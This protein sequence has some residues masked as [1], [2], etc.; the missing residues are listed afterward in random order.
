MRLHFLYG[1]QIINSW[2]NVS[3]SKLVIIRIPMMLKED[4]GP[5][6]LYFDYYVLVLEIN[7]HER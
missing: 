4:C 2:K 1:F 3:F 5:T 6:R 7:S